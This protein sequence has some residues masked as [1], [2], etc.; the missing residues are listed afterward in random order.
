M[1]D[2]VSKLDTET[3]PPTLS[4]KIESGEFDE[5]DADERGWIVYRARPDADGVQKETRV[6]VQHWSQ[7]ERSHK[8]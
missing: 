1:A 3:V 4:E 6:P 5:S 8:L 2:D 7:Y